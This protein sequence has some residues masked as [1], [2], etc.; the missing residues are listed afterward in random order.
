MRPPIAA[1]SESEEGA[2]IEGRGDGGSEGRIR[3]GMV[4]GGQGAFIGAVH[5]I[6]ARLDDQYSLVAGALS[7][8]SGRAI[9]SA[10]ELGLARERAYDSFEA[11]A[12]AEAA[13][14]DGI[15]AVAI[16]TPNHLHAPI[17]TAF[18]EAGVHVICDKPLATTVREAQA[19]VR[20]AKE[21]ARI[22][23]VTYNYT[24]Y[25]M[26]RQA[27]AMIAAGELG[28]IRL[29]QAEYVQ[30]WLTE[31]L[32]AT[33]QKQAA[34]RTDPA[35][36]GAGG[37]LGDIG[38]HAYHLACFVTGLTLDALC[39]DLTAFVTG[40]RLDDDAQML[41][42]F[43]GGARGMLW[44]SQVAPGNE[45]GLALRVYGTKGGL[46][47]SQEQPNHLWFTPF[48][49]PK[50]LITRGG[51]GA[52]EAAARV[53]RVPPGHPEGYL[54]GFAN[55]YRSAYDAMILRA[56]GKAFEKTNTIYPNVNDGVEGMYFIQQCVASSKQNGAW[57]PL[58][59][60]EAPTAGSVILAGVLLITYVPWLTLG[61]LQLF[62]VAF[63]VFALLRPWGRW[64]AAT[65]GALA[66]SAAIADRT[67]A[68]M[69]CLLMDGRA[70][71]ATELSAAVEVAP[72]TASAHL[73]KLLEQQLI[74]CVKQGRYRYFRLAGQPVAAALEGLMALAGVPRQSVKSRTPTSLQYARTCY[75]H[76]AGR[77][78]VRIS[79]GL[80]QQGHV[81]LGEDSG[82]V[83][84]H[85]R[86]FLEEFSKPQTNKDV[87]DIM[88]DFKAV[89]CPAPGEAESERADVIRHYTN[90][91]MHS[92]DIGTANDQVTFGGTCYGP[93]SGDAC[94]AV[95]VR[96][97]STDLRTGRTDPTRGI[98]HLTGAYSSADSRWW[99]CSSRYEHLGT[100]AHS[101]YSSK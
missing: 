17:A 70:Y 8:D 42:R 28:E 13:R 34:W 40:R 73:A 15:E 52:G 66:L 81:V 7:S 71:T 92:Y 97:N 31:P 41:L 21:R 89:A 30:D 82:I 49:E 69:L 87:N 11:M 10:L 86:R 44:A 75:D 6:A 96:W 64:V 3:L 50:R 67:R 77:L 9:A 54:E 79:D 95:P 38:T 93:L 58:A 19:L 45:N 68:R 36:A 55:L 48:G 27:R 63:G 51:A 46:E 24:G 26:V 1:C 23:A 88:R 12:T 74:A 20:L 61:L 91:V 53:S 4:G 39:A 2:V 60:T 57:L 78:G 84:A 80:Q 47:W 59:H 72:S 90:F 33:G 98:D 65:G 32:E 5:R 35:Q 62:G 85:G 101:F 83:T 16:V 56:E 76:M 22:F 25:P 99:L 37:A 18:L 14:K 29:V 94:I 100:I 43:Q